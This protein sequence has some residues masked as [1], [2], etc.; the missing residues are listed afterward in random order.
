MDAIRNAIDKR[1]GGRKL[2]NVQYFVIFM[3]TVIFVP[4]A[5]I[6][7]IVKLIIRRLAGW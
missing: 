7:E 3:M 4:F 5:V 6:G 1:A 2:N